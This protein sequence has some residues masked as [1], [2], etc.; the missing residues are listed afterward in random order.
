MAGFSKGGAVEAFTIPDGH[1]PLVIVAI[2]E[3]AADPSTLAPEIRERD[4]WPRERLPLSEI[5]F[6][7][8]WGHA[9]DASA[10]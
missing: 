8:K 6:T 3:L 1:R 9:Y 4:E 2:G 5:A 7:D 10:R